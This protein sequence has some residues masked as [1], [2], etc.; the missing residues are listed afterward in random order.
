M[1]AYMS[2]FWSLDSHGDSVGD[3]IRKRYNGIH[4]QGVAASSLPKRYRGLHLSPSGGPQWEPLQVVAKLTDE[5]DPAVLSV[6]IRG[7]P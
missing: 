6:S 4:C 3:S 2:A 7:S 1:A 5:L